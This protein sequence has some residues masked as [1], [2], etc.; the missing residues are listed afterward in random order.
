MKTK[1]EIKHREYSETTDTIAET[2]FVRS[3][4]E[5]TEEFAHDDAVYPEVSKA[6]I[7]PSY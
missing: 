2:D 6:L 3:Q 4:H 7:V 1:S 5:E